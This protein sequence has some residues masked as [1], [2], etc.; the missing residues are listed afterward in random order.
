MT[1][2]I[3]IAASLGL[4]GSIHCTAMCGPLMLYHFPKNSAPTPV[5]KFLL[6]HI[7]RTFAYT[8]LG[9]TFGQIGFISHLLGMQKLVSVVFG[10]ILLYTAS[11]YFLPGFFKFLPSVNWSS[12]FN[13]LFGFSNSTYYR[14]LLAGF[15]NGLLPCTLSFIAVSFAATT[16][17]MIYGALFMMIF[18]LSTIP[19]LALITWATQQI[20]L[21]NQLSKYVMPSI[22]F[23]TGLLL[24]LRSMNL[25]IPYISPHCEITE[26]RAIINCHK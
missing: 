5:L 3:F 25:G 18:G 24:I 23:I 14:F 7:A 16:Y 8:L 15:A 4:M 12:V 1:N 9:I 10:I 6:Y 17:S 26:K 11:R 21:S 2:L 22:A 20:K 19:S 13:T